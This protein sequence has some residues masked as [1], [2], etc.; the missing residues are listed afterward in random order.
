MI[1]SSTDIL[2]EVKRR[3][4][5]AMRGIPGAQF[6]YSQEPIP[7]TPYPVDAQPNARRPD[8]HQAGLPDRL[9]P[10]STQSRQ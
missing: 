4:T 9:S 2:C 8:I 10:Y 5:T 7:P 1:G 3:R 6:G